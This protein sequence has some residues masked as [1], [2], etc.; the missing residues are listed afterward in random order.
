M[1]KEVIA[2]AAEIIKSETAEWRDGTC[3][4]ALIDENGYPTASTMSIFKAE[5]IN[6]LTFATSLDSNKAKRIAGCNRAS[7]CVNSH[8]YNITLVGTIEVLTDPQVKK[9]NWHPFCGEFWTGPDDPNYC[10][11]IFTTERYNLYVCEQE[12]AGTL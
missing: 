5:G 12:A 11:L 8:N 9:D 4:L 3:T 1:S 6:R 7:V 10:V 2:R